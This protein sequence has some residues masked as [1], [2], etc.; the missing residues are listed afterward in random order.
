M[1]SARERWKEADRCRGGGL[2]PWRRQQGARGTPLGTGFGG[3]LTHSL[4]ERLH[5]QRASTVDISRSQGLNRSSAHAGASNKKGT[6]THT[7]SFTMF[8]ENGF[9]NHGS[10]VPLRQC[11]RISKRADPTTGQ[12]CFRQRQDS[13]VTAN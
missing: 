6:A 12:Q 10:K 5:Q 3:V 7:G 13:T 8:Q 11:P 2:L 9:K 4:P 1:Q